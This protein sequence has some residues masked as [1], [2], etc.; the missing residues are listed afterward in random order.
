MVQIVEANAPTVQVAAG[1][2]QNGVQPQETPRRPIVV[3]LI[4]SR[5]EQSR[6][7]QACQRIGL[8]RLAFSGVTTPGVP[9]ESTA[10]RRVP[11]P[12]L[13]C[14]KKSTSRRAA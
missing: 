8:R 10:E 11:Q 13:S 9:P 5:V 12:V 14:C 4:A 2:I 6:K 3:G 1:A 7:E